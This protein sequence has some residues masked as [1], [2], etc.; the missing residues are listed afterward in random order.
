MAAVLRQ[1]ELWLK[2]PPALLAAMLSLPIQQATLTRSVSWIHPQWIVPIRSTVPPID[3]IPVAT[4]L[5][6]LLVDKASPKASP[7]ANPTT[8]KVPVLTTNALPPKVDPAA[9]KADQDEAAATAR[10]D[11]E[12]V[13]SRARREAKIRVA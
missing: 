7:K 3:R 5:A 9:A 8:S 11:G 6:A 1:F 2:L 4:A 12:S 13:A 10:E